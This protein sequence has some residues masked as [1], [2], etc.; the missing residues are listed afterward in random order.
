ML[1]SALFTGMLVAVM[2]GCTGTDGD[3]AGDVTIAAGGYRDARR[4][5][6]V[7]DQRYC[8]SADADSA[9][10]LGAILVASLAPSGTV[11]VAD[12]RGLVA[13]DDA[14]VPHAISRQGDGPGELRAPFAMRA[15]SAGRVHVF[16]VRRMRYLVF[17]DTGAPTDVGA[18]PPMTM[19]NLRFGEAGLY[20]LSLPAAAAAGDSITAAVI[21][22][23]VTDTTWG[24]T[25]ALVPERAVFV[26]GSE[27]LFPPSLPWDR[28]VL[29][30]VCGGGDVVVA[31]TDR[32]RVVRYQRGRPPRTTG[33]PEI[34]GRPVPA[35]ERD[36][37]LAARMARGSPPASYRAA[38]ERRLALPGRHR[39]IDDLHCADDGRVYVRNAPEPGASVVRWD[40]LGTDGSLSGYFSSPVG[41]RVF[42]VR[43]NRLVGVQ[44]T[45]TGAE[46]I[47][48]L[49]VQ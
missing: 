28:T 33:R 46:Q 34:E 15:D 26:T 10:A 37:V 49:R 43:G 22:R 12:Q 8:A 45:D 20:V 32:W 27:G 23:A 11:I 1:R 3:A 38:L 48:R 35:A 25:V 4:I 36:S 29:W 5:S 30:D 6:A 14:G 39:V 19:L 31:A 7:I 42:D 40:V 17:P 9:C 18:L 24:D 47:V 21:R 44:E 16:D 41:L 13:F 2:S